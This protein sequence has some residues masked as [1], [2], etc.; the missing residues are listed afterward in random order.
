M[1]QTGLSAII[2]AANKSFNAIKFMPVNAEEI[3]LRC[4][5]PEDE[6]F[7]R[8]VHASTR[9]EEISAAGWPPEMRETFLNLQFTAQHRGYRT[10]FPKA[11]F[12]IILANGQA[13]GRMVV[14][15]S[16]AEILLVDI[17]LL[18]E[19]RNHGIG[20]VLIQRLADEAWNSGRPLRLSV[21]KG[22]RAGRLYQRLG[23]T[24]TG[25]SDMRDEMEWR[26]QDN[27]T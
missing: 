7:L 3:T 17:A 6:S 18:A 25:G 19:H 9:E 20:T 13:V 5:R 2:H 16:A 14:N 12:Q 8:E 27:Y 24:K 4:E 23:F 22:H 26:A 21:I 1:A 15:R 11:D 10:L